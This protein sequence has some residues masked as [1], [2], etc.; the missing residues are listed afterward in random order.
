MKTFISY[1]KA[2]QQG[3]RKPVIIITLIFLRDE[4]YQRL[5]HEHH[6]WEDLPVKCNN[7]RLQGINHPS[8]IDRLQRMVMV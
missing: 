1:E 2:E 5:P 4:G 7:T 8:M 3:I 6:V